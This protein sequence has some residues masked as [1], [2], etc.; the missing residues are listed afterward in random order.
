MAIYEPKLPNTII[1]VIARPRSG[2]SNPVKF[3]ENLNLSNL[4][5]FSWIA[6]AKRLDALLLLAMTAKN[7][8]FKF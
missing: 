4:S 6:S 3:R 1:R 5:E 7:T 2:R 8:R